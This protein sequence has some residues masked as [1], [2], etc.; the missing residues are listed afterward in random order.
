M[1]PSRLTLMQAIQSTWMQNE[2][3]WTTH[4]LENSRTRHSSFIMV[5][6]IVVSLEDIFAR[7]NPN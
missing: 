3:F 2:G 6:D 4:T 1:Q 5:R 7:A